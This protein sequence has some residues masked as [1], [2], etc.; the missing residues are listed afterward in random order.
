[1]MASIKTKTK[2][3]YRSEEQ[4]SEEPYFF[5]NFWNS[6]FCSSEYILEKK[7]TD[8]WAK[9]KSWTEVQVSLSTY[10][11]LCTINHCFLIW[12][13]F[14]F[15][16]DLTFLVFWKISLHQLTEDLRNWKVSFRQQI[17]SFGNYSMFL[18]S[19]VIMTRCL[20]LNQ[21]NTSKILLR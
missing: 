8:I 17:I 6:F 11:C 13:F 21:Q 14:T 7:M 10:Y 4:Y 3:S 12:L 1:M 15:V 9:T 20:L 18:N 19:S 2:L 16:L 5:D